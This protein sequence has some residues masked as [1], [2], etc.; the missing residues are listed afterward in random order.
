MRMAHKLAHEAEI[1]N[2]ALT[3]FGVLV[4]EWDTVG[5][6]P[7]LPDTLHGR[8]SFEWIEGGAF[9]MMHSDVDEPSVPSAIAILGSDDV[10]DEYFMVYFDERGVSRK[11]EMSLRGGLWKIWR[12]APKFSQRFTGTFADE[13]RTII[14]VWELCEDDVNWRRDLEMT[15]TR[16]G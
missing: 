16:I 3:P 11:Y 14:G 9:L 2:P 15:Y 13:G 1:T 4:G 6:H 8:A 5:S 7:A 10:K 12:D